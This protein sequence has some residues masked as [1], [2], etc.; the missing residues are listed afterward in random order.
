MSINRYKQVV[1][2]GYQ[3]NA[4]K[5][6]TTVPKPTEDDY[7]VGFI[8]RYF[9]QKTNDISSPI[10]E[11][12]IK[13]FRKLNSN[14]YYVVTSIKWKISGNL[15]PIYDDM[16]NIK[17][18]SVADSNRLSIRTVERDIKNLKLY[19]PNLLQFHKP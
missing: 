9:A 11:I 14:P 10:F 2:G 7:S 15:Q 16:G 3:F 4:P 6:K 12:D 13:N 18:K 1:K 8:Y 17:Y 5:F 19:L